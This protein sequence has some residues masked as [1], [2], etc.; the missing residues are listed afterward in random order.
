MEV[1]RA[2]K[3]KLKV[4]DYVIMQ[5]PKSNKLSMLFNPKPYQV[6]DIKGDMV[7]VR[8]A[9]HTVTWNGSFFKYLPNDQ[10]P[11]EEEQKDDE[12]DYGHG[13]AGTQQPEMVVENQR[14]PPE[15]QSRYHFR[16]NR[17]P[18]DYYR[19]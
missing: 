19:S 4:G 14:D 8:N 11:E 10:K 3:S 9:E 15:M 7:T 16:Q 2:K 18:P 6:I 17:K 13:V 12:E 5:V 1:K